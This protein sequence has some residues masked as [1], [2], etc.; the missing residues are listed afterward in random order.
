MNAVDKIKQTPSSLGFRGAKKIYPFGRAD[1]LEN[2]TTGLFLAL[3][4]SAMETKV[5]HNFMA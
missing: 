4:N 3:A 2:E 1:L 5:L